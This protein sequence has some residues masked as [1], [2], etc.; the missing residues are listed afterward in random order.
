MKEKKRPIRSAFS[1]SL[2]FGE[3]QQHYFAGAG[4]GFG[5]GVTG[6]DILFPERG[7]IMTVLAWVKYTPS[8]STSLFSSLP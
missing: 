6:C 2:P 4:A 1:L 3:A 5:A 7:L 8:A